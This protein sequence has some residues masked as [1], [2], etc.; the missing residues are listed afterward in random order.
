M[1]DLSF[2]SLRDLLRS[3]PNGLTFADLPGTVLEDL[4][5]GWSGGRRLAEV[6]AQLAT[7]IDGIPSS[8]RDSEIAGRALLTL[9]ARRGA[10][11]AV[12]TEGDHVRLLGSPEDD[13]GDPE[14]AAAFQAREAEYA[15]LAAMDSA[16]AV[17]EYVADVRGAFDA[18]RTGMPAAL[19][20][21]RVAGGHRLALLHT[22]LP[23][24]LRTWFHDRYDEQRADSL[25]WK[26]VLVGRGIARHRDGMLET[27]VLRALGDPDPA[28]PE[29]LVR[30]LLAL[31]LGELA[32]TAILEP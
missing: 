11:I 16:Y 8:G 17:G 26:F 22:G 28:V 3:R 19:P 32:R 18:A 13:E 30:A 14:G 29:E 31:D 2:D 24:G 23:A 9:L 25:A 5:L 10:P 21:D 20:P 6:A 12:R 15:S 4:A 1:S 27:G 7:R